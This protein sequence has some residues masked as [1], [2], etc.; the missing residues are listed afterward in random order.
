M[1]CK[2]TACTEKS[3]NASNAQPII[4]GSIIG[5]GLLYYVMQHYKRK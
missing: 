2:L 1:T 5:L 3:T 4:L